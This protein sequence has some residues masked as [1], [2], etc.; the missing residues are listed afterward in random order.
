MSRR[1][2]VPSIL[3]GLLIIVFVFT[4]TGDALSQQVRRVIVTNFPRVQLVTGE[5]EIRNPVRLAKLV[6]FEDI[7]VAPVPPTETTRLVEAGVLQTEGFPRVVL[8]LHG[9]VKGQVLSTGE[10]GVI[11]VPEQPSIQ[12]AFDEQGQVHFAMRTAARGVSSAT[13]YFASDQAE[14]TVGFQ[15]YK[16]YLY[17]TTDKTITA[18]LF[19]YLTN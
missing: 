12:E 6:T 19:A 5:V 11:L 17:N 9:I 4:P 18:N 16:I 15:A 2:V 3:F 8:S 1:I 10:V 14:F 13:P 7:I